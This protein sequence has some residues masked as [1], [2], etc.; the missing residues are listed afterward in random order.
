[1]GFSLALKTSGWAMV[2]LRYLASSTIFEKSRQVQN[3]QHQILI[4]LAQ[5]D[6][7]ENALFTRYRERKFANPLDI[8]LALALKTSGWAMVLL[9]YL[10]SSTIFEKSRQVR[11]DQHQI[12]IILAQVNVSDNAIFTR[13]RERKFAYPFCSLV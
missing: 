1:V 2:L 8:A 4:I 5:V 11:N 6:V 12:L 9:R 7:S 13:Y 3:D 10:A